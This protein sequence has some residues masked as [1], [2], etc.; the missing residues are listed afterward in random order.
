MDIGLEFSEGLVQGGGADIVGPF[1]LVGAYDAKSGSVRWVKRY[2]THA[3]EYEGAAEAQHGIWGLWTIK[4]QE[5]GG[6][7]IKPAG[8]DQGS[9]R[10]LEA[11]IPVL[12]LVELSAAG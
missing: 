10:E 11:E 1:S 9:T 4:G 7:Q 3:V 5:R 2:E 12:V 6:F 8:S